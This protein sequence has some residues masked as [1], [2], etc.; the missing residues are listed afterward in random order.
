M[1]FVKV[2]F[3]GYAINRSVPSRDIQQVLMLLVVAQEPYPCIRLRI[4]LV[5]KR[6][7]GLRKL[8]LTQL[9]IIGTA[10]TKE[11]HLCDFTSTVPI[12]LF[13]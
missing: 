10:D 9:K 1:I 11:S 12:I 7:V 8:W 13:L 2:D 6:L 5:L 4:I 3:S